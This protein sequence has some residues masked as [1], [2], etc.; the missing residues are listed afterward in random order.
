[1]YSLSYYIR[2]NSTYEPILISDDLDINLHGNFLSS[3]FGI[4]LFQ[5]S[6][7]EILRCFKNYNILP[8]YVKELEIENLNIYELNSKIKKKTYEPEIKKLFKK[9]LL[10]LNPKIENERQYKIIIKK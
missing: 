1:M 4:T 5:L 3:Y 8:K 2:N 9:C 7:Y 6:S 10:S